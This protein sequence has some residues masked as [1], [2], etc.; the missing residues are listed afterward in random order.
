MKTSLA[1]FA[2]AFAVLLAAD[3]PFAA[4]GEPVAAPVNAD[5]EPV[6][7]NKD[8]APILFHQCVECHR[9]G[10]VAPFSL[11]TYDDA[12]KRSKMIRSVTSE[13]IMPPWKS[14]EGNGSFVG[15]R[16]LAA[17]EIDLV[18]RWVTQGKLEGDAKDLPAP[19]Q[20]TDGLETGAARHRAENGRAVRNSRRRSRRLSQF[21]LHPRHPKGKYIKAAEFRPSNRRVVHHAQLCVDTTGRGRKQDAADPA[22]GFD[23][24]GSPPGQLFPGSMATWTPGR[25]PI[26]LPDGISMPWKEGADFVV[27]LHL[28]PSGKPEAE[29]SSIGFYLTDQPPQRSMADL[30]LIDMKIDIPP[31]EPSYRTRA[32]LTLPID[33]ETVGLFPHMHMIGRE[34]KLTAYPPQGEPISL[35]WIND[36]DFNWQVYYQYT[37]PMR[38]TAGT[39]VVMESVHDNSADNIRNP[40]QPPKRVTWG[41][42]TTDEMS[43]AFFQVMPVREEDFDKLGVNER[44]GK[45]GVIRAVDR[46]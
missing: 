30:L 26:P 6:T 39:R 3:S 44:R 34:F 46:K 35:L 23:G 15:E 4:Q 10:Q 36:W 19:P 41:E 18:D 16:R 7:F 13:H 24:A 33:V 45:L 43:L 9:P 32:Q 20:Y 11:L 21:R 40:N 38:L 25:D 22:P 12:K 1:G 5:A 2:F 42:Q 17:S 14:V 28:H 29:Q 37:V 27:Q 8:I 31:G